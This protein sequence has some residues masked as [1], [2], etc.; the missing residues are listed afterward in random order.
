[1]FQRPVLQVLHQFAR[2][3]YEIVSSLV[4][5]RSLNHV[6]LLEQVGQNPVMRQVEGKKSSHNIFSS[7]KQNA[8]IRGQ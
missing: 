6:Q 4:L 5:E 3:E 1:M 7:N 2:Q 8:T